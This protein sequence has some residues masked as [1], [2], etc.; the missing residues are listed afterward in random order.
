[1]K[2]ST[3]TSFTIG[4]SDLQLL[5]QLQQWKFGHSFD[6][7]GEEQEIS[8]YILK[9]GC[10]DQKFELGTIVIIVSVLCANREIMSA[11]KIW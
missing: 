9:S 6:V 8:K 11:S 2:I 4:V 1:M 5:E 3:V 7:V 10:I